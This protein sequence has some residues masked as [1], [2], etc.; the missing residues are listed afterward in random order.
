MA[1]PPRLGAPP[2]LVMP[3]LEVVPPVETG[4]VPPLPA[5]D[6]IPELGPRPTR[7]EA[8]FFVDWGVA[9]RQMVSDNIEH[10]G[11]REI[12]EADNRELGDI[13]RRIEPAA[14]LGGS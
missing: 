4:A 8:E 9:L 1:R 12:G 11:G 5:V 10:E 6:T 3:P 2:G 13:L 14:A 7:W